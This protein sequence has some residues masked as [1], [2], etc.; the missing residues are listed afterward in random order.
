MHRLWSYALE[1]TYK[2]YFLT[3]SYGFRSYENIFDL[4]KE[5]LFR[6]NKVGEKGNKKIVTINID[7]LLNKEGLH[8]LL[9]DLIFPAK[10]KLR[11]IKAF[12]MG[13]KKKISSK[14]NQRN[15]LSFLLFNV[16]LQGIENIICENGFIC[17][18]RYNFNLIYILEANENE[19]I[20]L[21]KIKQFLDN[22]GFDLN[23]K[24]IKIVSLID[25]FDFLYWHF[26]ILSNNQII[27]YPSKNNWMTY[28]NKIKSTLKTSRYPMPIRIEKINKISK[29]WFYCHQYCDR[30]YITSQLYFLKSW[31]QKYLKSKTKMT[32][33]EIN[34]SFEYTFKNCIV[35]LKK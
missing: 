8:T 7:Q 20:L 13:W 22:R 25:G 18:F 1:P 27:T 35:P 2:S 30:S 19:D 32:R 11:L 31:F 29:E 34:Y 16:A 15:I 5:I 21:I 33:K 23:L 28:K 14:L 3:N 9:R 4:Q 26:T 6:L 24:K 12:E 17:G 10:D